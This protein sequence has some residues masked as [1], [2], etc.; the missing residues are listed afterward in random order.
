LNTDALKDLIADAGSQGTVEVV[1]A[2]E[3]EARLAE[4]TPAQQEIV[5]NDEKI[6]EVFDVSVLV[7]KAKRDFDTQTG[8]VTLGL[9]YTLKAGEKPA[10]IGIIYVRE[11]GITEPMSTTY[12]E[13]KKLA[14]FKTSHL[15]IY[16]VTYAESAA[17]PDDDDDDKPIDNDPLTPSGNSGGGCEAGMGV[18][19]LALLGAMALKKRR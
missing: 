9:P 2:K 17:P 7:N 3:D 19:S 11:D 6:R 10:N 13:T 18:L 5:R 4:L 8:T 16:A 12:N 14:V 15:S 1:I